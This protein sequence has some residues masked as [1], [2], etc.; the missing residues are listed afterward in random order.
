MTSLAARLLALVSLALLSALALGAA[1]PPT[2]GAPP[3]GTVPQAA[4]FD[5]QWP[6]GRIER[7][8]AFTFDAEADGALG[9]LRLLRRSDAAAESERASPAD[10]PGPDAVEITLWNGDALV[11]TI[12]PGRTS[13]E[14]L[15]VAVGGRSELA[16]DVPIDALRRVAFDARRA[17]AG[18]ERLEAPEVGDR[19]YRLAG[20]GVDVLDGTLDGFGAEGV[21]FESS[22]GLR[23]YPWSDVVALFVEPLDPPASTRGEPGSVAVDLVGGGRLHGTLEAVGE[24]L[25][26]LRLPWD[27]VF[28]TALDS[29]LLVGRDDGSIAYLSEREPLE[30]RGGSAFDDDLGHVFVPRDDRAVHGEPLRAGGRVWPRGIGVQAPTTLVFDVSGDAVGDGAGE[31]SV[32]L[33]GA[34]AIDDST[35]ELGASGAA[36]FVVRVERGGTWREVWRSDVVRG[37]RAPIA[38]PKL[39]LSGANR[40]ELEVEMGPDLNLGDR[41]DWLDVRLVRASS[42]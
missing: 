2:S 29:V 17:A 16:L 32:E 22:L 6:D 28:A 5:L 40:L 15:G 41:A 39:D 24:S 13:V 33:R 31:G 9:P 19:L 20:T 30:F 27:A 14:R 23:T 26:R 3:T 42:R 34:V 36:V 12:D 8:V 18:A 1:G 11:G 10:G 38:L 4:G 37:G 7:G 35:A 25:L 21:S